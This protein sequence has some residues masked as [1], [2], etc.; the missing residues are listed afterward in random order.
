VRDI[1]KARSE[2]R[3]K[4]KVRLKL[5]QT[6]SNL[7]SGGNVRARWLELGRVP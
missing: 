4:I 3:A 7:R 6:A 1:C 2:W 5:T